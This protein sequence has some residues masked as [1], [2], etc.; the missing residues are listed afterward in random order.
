[1]QARIVDTNKYPN[2]SNGLY[3]VVVGPYDKARAERTLASIRGVVG[4]AYIKSGR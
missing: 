3:A 2:L 4:D 1:V